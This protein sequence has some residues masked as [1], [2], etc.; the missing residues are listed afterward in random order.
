[1]NRAQLY[2]WSL[3]HAGEPLS[4]SVLSEFAG[5]ASSLLPIADKELRKSDMEATVGAWADRADLPDSF[6]YIANLRNE[7]RDQRLIPA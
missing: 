4:E 1:M 3:L 6:T 2:L 5:Q 7:V